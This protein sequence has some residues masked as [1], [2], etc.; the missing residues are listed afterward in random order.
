M[1]IAVFA[2]LHGRLLLAFKLCARWQ[3]ETGERI[4]LILQA[5]DLGA[6][7]AR[8]RLDR[9]TRAYA[10]RDP[11][12]LGFMDHFTRYDAQVAAQL[13]MTDCPLV[14]VRGNHEDHFWLDELERQCASAIFPI[15]AYQRVYHLRT[16][17]PWTFQRQDERITVLGIGRIAPPAEAEDRQQARYIQQDESARV[18]ALGTDPVDVL[19]THHAR[20]DFVLLERAGTT[21]RA[22]SG[23]PEIASLLER[24]RPTCHFFGHYGGPPQVR[25]DPNGITLSVKLADLHWEHNGSALQAGSMGLLHWQSR[26]QYTF[27]VLDTPWLRA[28]NAWTWRD[29]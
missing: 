28:Y 16:G 25:T 3:Q 21:I 10:E 6:Y 15:D 24:K 14:F 19:L 29:L 2:D 13:A 18:Y 20:P 27:E 26:T 1:H 9:A 7:P 4:D 12:E 23:M 5:G 22:G 11:T 17:L 8:E